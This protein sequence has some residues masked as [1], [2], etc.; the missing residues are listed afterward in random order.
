MASIV[1]KVL[2]GLI[3]SVM[4]A[5]GPYWLYGRERARNTELKAEV[6]QYKSELS[7]REQEILRLLSAVERQNADIERWKAE[8]QKQTEKTRAA[9]AV[10][11]KQRDNAEYAARVI[12]TSEPPTQAHLIVE[13]HRLASWSL[14]KP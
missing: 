1:L 7:K 9:E 3:A 13:A 14:E 12:L 11:Q 4:G 2:L 8:G 10:A 6:Q 5:L